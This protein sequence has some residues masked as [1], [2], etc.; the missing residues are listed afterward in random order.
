MR[1]IRVALKNNAYDIVVG[2]GVLSKLPDYLKKLG[3]GPDAVIITNPLVRR[4]HGRA[5]ASA[6][7]PG[8]LRRLTRKKA[9]QLPWPFA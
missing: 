3:L 6:L 1:S 9:N 7:F 2:S 5:L 4:L 8:S